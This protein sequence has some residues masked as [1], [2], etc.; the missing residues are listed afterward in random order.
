[1]K[2]LPSFV[3]DSYLKQFAAIVAIVLVVVAGAGFFFQGEVTEELRHERQ[4]ELRTIA[5]LEADAVSDWLNRNSEKT[6]LLSEFGAVRSGDR[7]RIDSTLDHELEQFESTRA[8]HYVDL[9]SRQI[10]ESTSDDRVGTTVPEVTWAHG[11][12]RMD[13]PSAVAITEGYRQDG[14]EVIAFLSRIEGTDR[15][16]MLT[17]N[18]RER[19]DKFRTPTESSFTQVVDSHGVVEFAQNEEAALEPYQHGDGHIQ[20][21]QNGETGVMDMPGKDLV[22]GYAPVEGADWVVVTHLPRSEAYALAGIVTRDFLSLI[23]ISLAGFLLIGLT[24]GRDTV[25]VLDRLT[26]DAQSIAQ[27]NLDVEVES[28]DREDEIG[29]MTAA[30]AEMQDYLST[31]AAQAEAV[32]EQRFDAPVLDQEVPGAFGETIDRM[33]DDVERAQREAKEAK[34]NAE[35]A[36]REVEDLND[37]L[38]ATAET[39]GETMAA[40]ADGDLTQRMD[41]DSRSAAMETIAE[42]FND[43]MAEMEG[44]LSRI[45]SFADEVA[46]ASQQVTAST[47]EVRSASAEVSESIQE[48]SAGAERQDERLTE[49]SG[50]MQSLSGAIEEVA[51][52]ADEVASTADRA[53]EISESGSD[54]AADAIDELAQIEARTDET[55]DEV[56]SLAEEIDEISEIVE[57]IADIA[58]QTNMLALN[59]SIEAARADVDGDGFA[60]VADE[61]K[62]LASE[63]AD[64]T[65]RIDR[66]IADVQASAN[67]AVDDM[68]AM[69]EGVEHGAETIDEALTSLDEVADHVEDLHTGVREISEAT[70]DQ[71]A[72]TGDVVSML[73]EVERVADRSSAEAANVSAAAEEQ[74]STLADVSQSAQ[75]LTEQ[76]DSLQELLD[77]FTAD[78]RTVST[79]ATG[80]T[81]ARASTDG[82]LDG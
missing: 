28:S 6:R 82:G 8:I 30:F 21:A 76:A 74:T 25:T 35:A 70:D 11:S 75:A 42:S 29:E 58:E 34:Q 47:E 61:I 49:I 37:D 10:V 43:M 53:A 20:K 17:A 38:E 12:F 77:Q 32:A 57:L 80:A 60:V 81:D 22:V 5:E 69:G 48:V 24:L 55:V 40:A 52:S 26:E 78:A 68:Q 13:D 67:G 65:E 33:S 7:E 3:R 1:M 59:A 66:R 19:A 46:T 64:A 2:F 62:S 41:T 79:D 56:V 51:S 18:A 36:R 31:V 27:G 15:A 23:G 73:D 50:E 44:T 39:F 71:A 9:D 4:N 54:A 63:A 72:S 14:T 16:I 45:R